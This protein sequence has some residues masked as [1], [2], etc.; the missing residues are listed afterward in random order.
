MWK[1]K[2]QINRQ[3]PPTAQSVGASQTKISLPLMSDRFL[4]SQY[5]RFDGGVRFGKLLE[6][7]DAIAGNVAFMHTQGKTVNVTAIVDNIGVRRHIPM[8][9][10]L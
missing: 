9:A 3:D 10:D 1:K 7:M 4:N 6:D 5:I 2:F 8:D